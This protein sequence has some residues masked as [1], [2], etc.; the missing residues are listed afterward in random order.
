MTSSGLAESPALEVE[1]PRRKNALAERNAAL[2]GSISVS[3]CSPLRE[4]AKSF[5]RHECLYFGAEGISSSGPALKSST[6]HG[7]ETS[8]STDCEASATIGCAYDSM[9]TP[10]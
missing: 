6:P 7:Q 3:I 9:C 5:H 10:R 4:P 1:V 2:A 8:A